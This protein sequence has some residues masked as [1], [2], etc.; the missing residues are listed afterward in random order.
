MNNKT[1]MTADSADLP[2]PLRVLRKRLRAL[3]LWT[4]AKGGGKASPGWGSLAEMGEAAPRA[5]QRWFEPMDRYSAWRAVNVLTPAALS[6][7]QQ[8]IKVAR[9]KVRFSI[10]TPVYNTGAEH[11]HET[12]QSVLGQ[13]YG[14]WELWL[15]DDA[16]TNTDT[17]RA[18]AEVAGLDKRIRTLA[19]SQNGGIS[20]ATNAA[21]AKAKGDV[22]VFLDHDDLLT[23]DCLA[24]LAL[25]YTAHPDA[26]IVYSDD[27]KLDDEGRFYAPQFKP[28][29]SPALLTSFMYMSHVF[30]VRRSLFAELGGFRSDFDG[31]Q[32]YDFA[33]RASERARHVGHIPRVLYHWRAVVGSTAVSGEAK[34][35]S[36]EAGRRAV[37]GHLDR[38]GVA[39]QVTHPDWA[40]AAKVGMFSIRFPD[41]GPLVTII[42]PTYNAVDLLS[43]CLKSLE[44]TTYRNYRVMVVDNDSDC[45]DTL[46][47]LESV[48]LEPHVWVERISKSDGRF[49]YAALMNEAV[50]RADGD[51]ILFLNN[52]TKVIEP[53][54]LSQMVGLAGFE[55]VG[56]VGARLRFADDHIQHAGIIQGYH[57]GLAGHAFRGLHASQWGYL[58]LMRA[59]HEQ[60]A[61]TA[62]CMLTPRALFRE[63]GGFD[64]TTFAVAYNDA[65][66]GF[67]LHQAGYRN[68]Y[69]PE[70]ELY[71]FEGRTRAKVDDP[72]EVASMRKL[73]GRAVDPF[74]NPNLSLD[75]ELLQ[76]AAR[77]LPM[78]AARPVKVGVFSHNLRHEGAP[79]TLCDLIVGLQKAGVIEPIV[80]APATGPL[81]FDYAE[82]GIEVRLVSEA[83][84]DSNLAD[85]VAVQSTLATEFRSAAL[86]V[87]VANTLTAHHAIGAAARAGLPSIWCQH[88]SEPWSGYYNALAPAVQ[89]HAYAAFAQAYAVTYVAD[90]TR[91]AWGAVQTRFNA[92]TIRHA[93]P[94]SILAEETSRWTRKE[95][96]RRLGLHEDEVVV[97]LPG[98]VCARKGQQDIV[99]AVL[100]LPPEQRERIKILIVGALV[101]PEYAVRLASTIE[102][103]E[104]AVAS[105]IEL[106]GPV[107]D[108]SLYYAASDMMACTSRTESAPRVLVEAMAFG[109][110]IVT[111]PV[112][113]IP[114]VVEEGVNAIFY[115]PGD[116]KAL[117]GHISV[118]AAD[119]ER[120]AVMADAGRAVLKSRPNYDDMLQKYAALIR[121][122]ALAGSWKAIDDR[123]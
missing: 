108:M 109:L 32:D 35:H 123:Y 72:R 87:I 46:A 10:I 52:D 7:L 98:T 65:D 88:E 43:V 73:Y 115:S 1:L 121:E 62:A 104:L 58:G 15:S 9:P 86:E 48:S 116:T 57:D 27:D 77:R 17:R 78:R 51:L 122:A 89:F 61:V 22:L 14:D 68:L 45:P 28:D 59:P 11:L 67:R 56:S 4:T 20:V 49:N 63:M 29:W 114:E 107:D 60:M 75:D 16:S 8:A 102:A 74:H 71:H 119:V 105:R 42:V 69:C 50:A 25:Y 91:R 117:A 90:A 113:G 66:Y 76:V 85:Y 120:R 101:E 47:Y 81:E 97:I 5:L 99:D 79:K 110:P 100:L 38:V 40:Q 83:S 23:P 13:V 36:F 24:E 26:D 34:P 84:P 19:S 39:G 55:G 92:V 70:A 103:C 44:L 33:L 82:A 37:Q 6:D 93:I 12:V 106:V 64:A 80:Y 95:A 118:L 54:W 2:R 3:G 31:S 30:T 96:R 111:T 41:E 112:F 18:L 21:A 53:S 94:A